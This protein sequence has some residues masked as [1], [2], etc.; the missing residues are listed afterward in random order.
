MMKLLVMDVVYD[1]ENEV[2]F[3]MQN[4]MSHSFAKLM[5]DQV[6]KMVALLINFIYCTLSAHNN[7]LIA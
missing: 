7:G 5:F 1:A 4:Q 3:Y 2:K 6:R